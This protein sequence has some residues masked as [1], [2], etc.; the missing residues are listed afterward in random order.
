MFP[1]DKVEVREVSY[2]NKIRSFIKKQVKLYPEDMRE[3]AA[4][5]MEVI[6]AQTVELMMIY[7]WI[8]NM[9]GKRLL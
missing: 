9:S 3:T 7:Y 4:N 5:L 1:K 8:S 6:G 2:K